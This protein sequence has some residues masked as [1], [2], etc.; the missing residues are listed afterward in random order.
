M[1]RVE[2]APVGKTVSWLPPL[3][4][5]TLLMAVL[6]GAMGFYVLYPLALILLNSFNVATTLW[7]DPDR[8]ASTIAIATEAAK[9]P[10]LAS[11]QPVDEKELNKAVT[12]T[13]KMLRTLPIG[14]NCPAAGPGKEFHYWTCAQEE[15]K[16]L[17]LVQLFGWIL[18]AAALSL[19]APFWFD[20]LNQFI[21]LRGAGTKPA[22]E[23]QKK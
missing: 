19:G 18:T 4:G 5:G 3:D 21:N 15:F 12:Y 23:D 11:T 9:K 22:R 14:W 17:T 13:E 1:S 7:N 8:R 10:P 6:I 16:K 2:T 20:L